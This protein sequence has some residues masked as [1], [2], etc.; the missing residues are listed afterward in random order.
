MEFLQQVKIYAT[1]IFGQANYNNATSVNFG[2]GN[3]GKTLLALQVTF[4][5]ASNVLT[6]P[7]SGQINVIGSNDNN[8][9]LVP[10]LQWSFGSVGSQGQQNNGDV[11]DN[12]QG[13]IR[14]AQVSWGAPI[15]WGSATYAVITFNAN[16]PKDN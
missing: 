1:P 5:N 15:V 8:F 2:F 6:A 9:G 13:P 7:T 14:Y 10:T 16:A 11:V 12:T 4:Y 3:E